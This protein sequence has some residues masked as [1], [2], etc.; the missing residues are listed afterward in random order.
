VRRAAAAV[1]ALAAL[2]TLSA[3]ACSTDGRALRPPPPGATAP[4]RSVSTTEAI[5]TVPATA[6]AFELTSAAFTDGQP[7]PSRFGCGG[8]SPPLAW[9]GIPA[10]TAELA[11]VV[12][13]P[14]AGSAVVWAAWDIDPATAGLTEGEEPA[15]GTGWPGPCPEP[16]SAH[17]Y[18][19]TLHALSRALDLPQGTGGP[20]AL[21]AIVAASAA[22]TTLNATLAR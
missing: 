20:E 13:D 17:R 11:L 12:T 3:V 9:T 14:D 21:E 22:Q 8:P 4:P 15:S 5:G 6:A 1:L 2:S 7:I 18:V 16:G 10:G 19:F